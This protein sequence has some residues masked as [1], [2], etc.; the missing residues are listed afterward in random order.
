MSMFSQLLAISFL[1]LLV[2]LLLFVIF[3]QVTVR[4]LRQNPETKDSLGFEYASGTDIANVVKVL[5]VSKHRAEKLRHGKM[6]FLYAD[7]ELIYNHTNRFDRL[8]AK[9]VYWLLILGGGSMII[10]MIGKFTGI[11][12]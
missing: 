8:L 6:S 9:S 3:G 10:L 12:D 7:R 2:A 1:V 11:L 5:S 4:K